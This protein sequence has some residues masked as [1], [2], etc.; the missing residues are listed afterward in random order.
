MR[1]RESLHLMEEL[2][3]INGWPRIG[4]LRM[5]A[6]LSVGQVGTQSTS[7]MITRDVSVMLGIPLIHSV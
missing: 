2:T 1:H 4:V 5:N 7:S 6:I 3:S